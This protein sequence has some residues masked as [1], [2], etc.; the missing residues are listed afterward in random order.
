MQH[1]FKWG[2]SL[3]WKSVILSHPNLH[4]LCFNW[5]LKS[6]YAPAWIQFITGC[7]ICSLK[8]S[9]PNCICSLSIYIFKTLPNLSNMFATLAHFFPNLLMDVCSE[10]Y[11]NK[12][13]W[14]IAMAG[15]RCQVLFYQTSNMQWV[16]SAPWLDC[17]PLSN[18]L[19]MGWLADMQS[20]LVSPVS[21]FPLLAQFMICIQGVTRQE[22][23]GYKNCLFKKPDM[24]TK[25]QLTEPKPKPWQYEQP[26]PKPQPLKRGRSQSF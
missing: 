16:P 15:L 11:P 25:P 20:H 18:T 4:V 14:C 10:N 13:P 5:N 9:C 23:G 8:N 12:E 21:F 1:Q 19:I 3:F 17:H 24:G 6:F 2:G 26:K 7:P 22:G